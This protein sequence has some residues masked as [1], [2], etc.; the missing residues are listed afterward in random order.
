[1]TDYLR[2][3]LHGTITTRVVCAMVF[4]SFVFLW[5]YFFQ[6]DILTVVQHKLSG[7]QTHYHRTIGA[8]VITLILMLLQF[9]VYG[10]T[11]LA[12]RTHALTYLPSMLLLAFICHFPADER[13]D[14]FSWGYWAW[15][16]PIVLVLWAVA[17]WLARQLLPFETD[18]KVPT[19][20]FSRRMW[21]NMLQM[22]AMMLLVVAASNTEAVLHFRTHAETSLMRNDIK[23]VLRAGRRSR[24][25]DVNLTML[26]LHALARQ[27]EVGEHLFDYPVQG[28]STDMLPL[29]KSHFN[30]LLLSS[31]SLWK[32]FG[33]R[34]R[35]QMTSAFYLK[36]LEGDTISHP[37]VRD[38]ILCGYLIDRNL[39][40]Y[41]SALVKYYPD[42]IKLPR[43]YAEA[44][45]LSRT[46]NHVQPKELKKGT[47]SYYYYTK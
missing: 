47:Y 38:Y 5:L 27:G 19:G 41:T 45:E 18:A 34:P 1:M 40:D 15:L 21:V 24:E 29:L 4:V 9:G 20:L 3:K 13:G 31:D 22:V 14:V 43:F 8:V 11:R 32:A 12:R 26:R 42:T 16:A 46:P 10:I 37:M 6:A 39:T 35:Y 30:L 44:L 17:V 36:A 33:A 25:T 28:R 23:E 7:G 2:H